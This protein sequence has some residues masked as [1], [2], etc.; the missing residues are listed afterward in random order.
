MS[1]SSFQELRPKTVFVGIGKCGGYN[2]REDVERFN[3]ETEK[4]DRRACGA[5]F[6]EVEV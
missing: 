6:A 5:N 4:M 2:T 1:I 3:D